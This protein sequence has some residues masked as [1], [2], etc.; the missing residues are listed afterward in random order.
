MEAITCLSKL[1]MYRK[2]VRE[3]TNE[4][5]PAV[6]DRMALLIL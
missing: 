3:K 4:A 2:A 6:P 1:V 5:S